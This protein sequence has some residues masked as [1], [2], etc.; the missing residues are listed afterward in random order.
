MENIPACRYFGKRSILIQILNF[1][2][3]LTKVDQGAIIH[4]STYLHTR[5]D[6]KT[7]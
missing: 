3:A 2:T 1:K 7:K 5:H 6:E 4:A